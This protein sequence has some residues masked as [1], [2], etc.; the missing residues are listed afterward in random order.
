M[1]ILLVLLV[2]VL[3][4]AGQLCQK[5]FAGVWAK[6]PG[7]KRKSRGA[8]WLGLSILFLG[9]GLLLWLAVLR[10]MPVSVAY[11]FLSLNFV[12]VALAARFFFHEH[13]SRRQCFGI[14]W[15]ISGI[16]FLSAGL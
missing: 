5:Q 9:L 11:P 1:D 13:I 15:I 7:P 12:L 8:L 14:V 16:F 6:A 10:L 3:T 2:C 4:C